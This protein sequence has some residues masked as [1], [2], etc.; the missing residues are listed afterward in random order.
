MK[1]HILLLCYLLLF[2]FIEGRAQ[3]YNIALGLNGLP[4]KSSL[5]NI[6]K[7][8]TVVSYQSLWN[9]FEQTDAK[10]NGKVWDM[11][12]DIPN[13][14]PV[15][16]FTFGT[17]QCGSYSAEGSC[18]NREHT[19]PKEYFGGDAQS[20]SPMYSDLHHL[21]ATDGWV[22]NKH[23]AFP[24]GKVTSSAP[25]TSSNGTK[26]GTGNTYPGYTDKLF[27][28]INEYKGDFARAYFYFSVRYMGEEDALWQNWE[29]ASGA[30]L[31]PAAVTLLLAWHQLDPVSAKEIARN[32]EVF[33]IQGNRNPFVDYPT[34]A[35]CIWGSGNCLS[36]SIPNV[37]FTETLEIFPNPTSN[38]IIVKNK[39]A[40]K[41]E[42]LLLIDFTGRIVARKGNEQTNEI[43][44]QYLPIGMYV[45][46]IIMANGES[47]QSKIVKE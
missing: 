23:A 30:N 43:N 20:A 14:T 25:Y 33:A 47:Y 29:M 1:K 37:S 11:Y 38:Y 16:V 12:T 5:H 46:K 26:L 8:H 6:I 42:E 10:A 3:Y 2:A 4:L 31:N 36:L 45:L 9:H 17:N 7:N 22:N 44:L 35:E 32:N 40:V 15:H 18:Y 28:P 39:S 34:F 21:F 13:S 41:I 27:E 19:W 24:F